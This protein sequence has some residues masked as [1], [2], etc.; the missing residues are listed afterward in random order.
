[1]GVWISVQAANNQTAITD[2][3][4]SASSS[5][6]GNSF[7]WVALSPNQ[8]FWC[9]APSYSTCYSNTGPSSGYQVELAYTGGWPQTY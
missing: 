7:Y 5:Y 4:F 8:D 3:T 1:M 6:Y 2:A 9:K